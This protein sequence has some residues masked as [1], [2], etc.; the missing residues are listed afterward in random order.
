MRSDKRPG[1]GCFDKSVDSKL[2]TVLPL[3]RSFSIYELVE[4]RIVPGLFTQS[5]QNIF[6]ALCQLSH[7]LPPL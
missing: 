4:D 1:A 7:K 2:M 6:N 5:D 3:I